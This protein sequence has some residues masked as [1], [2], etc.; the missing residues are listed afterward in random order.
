MEINTCEKYVLAELET[1]KRRNAELEEMI[2][3]LNFS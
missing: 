3:G 1:Y 2:E